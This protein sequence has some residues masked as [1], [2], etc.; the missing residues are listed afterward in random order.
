[1]LIQNANSATPQAAAPAGIPVASSPDIQTVAAP[2][3]AQA[4]QAAPS[5]AQLQSAVQSSN[6]AISGKGLEFSVDTSTKQTVVKLM[7]TQS[8]T[9]IGQFPSQQ[10]IDISKSIGLMQEQLQQASL[11][12]TPVQASPGLLIKQ[13]A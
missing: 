8:D 12:R 1:M 11:S 9:V 13:Q 2:Q 4:P 3:A 10:M 6:Q 5:T 7:D